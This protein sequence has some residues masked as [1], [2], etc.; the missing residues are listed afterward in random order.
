LTVSSESN[1]KLAAASG[2]V[3]AVCEIMSPSATAAP[4]KL[5][6]LSSSSTVKVASHRPGAE[7]DDEQAA[8][9]PLHVDDLTD[10]GGGR[11]RAGDRA[12]APEPA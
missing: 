11:W 10:R 3:P 2:A 1:W 7:R 9:V 6:A 8:A 4:E 5:V 12:R